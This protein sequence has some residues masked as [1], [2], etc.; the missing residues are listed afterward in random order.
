MTP[1]A[2]LREVRGLSH[3]EAADMPPVDS[4]TPPT[5]RPGVSSGPGHEVLTAVGVHTG[6]AAVTHGK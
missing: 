1:F 4:I 2:L 6:R 3:R 5:A